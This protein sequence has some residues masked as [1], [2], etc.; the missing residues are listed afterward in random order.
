MKSMSIDEGEDN[1]ILEEQSDVETKKQEAITFK[2]KGN[3]FVKAKDYDAALKMYTRAIE[4]Y[5]SDPVFFSNRSQ[6]YLSLDKYRECV[7]DATR[8]I[9][10]DPNSAKSFYRRMAAYEKLGEDYKAMQS[11]RQWLDLAPEDSSA[12]KSYDRI[13]NRIAEAEKKKDKE[14]I[15]WSRLSSSSEVVDFV[16]RPPHLRSKRPLKN[17]PVELQKAASPIPESLI[18]R[19]FDNNTGEAPP[20]TNSKLFKSNFLAAPK[21]QLPAADAKPEIKLEIIDDKKKLNEKNETLKAAETK[22]EELPTLE[23]LE[24]QK[25]HLI[26]IPLSG[27]QFYAAWKEFNDAQRFLYLKNIVESNAP[28]GKLLGAQLDSEMLTDIIRI[29]HKFFMPY[30]INFVRVL[31][32]LR[33]N[34]E[35][36]MLV[37]FLDADDKKSEKIVIKFNKLIPFNCFIFRT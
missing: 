21:A 20:E 32:D 14:K 9:E 34:T 27:P 31:S 26:T 37:M 17:V 16:S 23:E 3:T 13:H 18:D 5:D 28:I 35:I 1:K 15:R 19:I 7:E 12:E 29:L 6:C 8:A 30:N 22:K 25:S 33:S 11:C 4:L 2:D 10:L 24:A 36:E